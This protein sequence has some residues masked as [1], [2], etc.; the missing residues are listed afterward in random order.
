MI[1]IIVPAYNEEQRIEKTLLDYSDYF[2]KNQKD[3]EIIVVCDG[4]DRTAKIVK[5]IMNDRKNIRMAEFRKKLGKGGA[6]IEGF[7]AAKG[8]IIGFTD[9]DESVSPEDFYMLSKRI[10]GNDCV[11][12]S[13][14]ATGAKILVAQPLKRRLASRLFNIFI[15]VV[16]GLGVK[17]TQCGVKIARKSAI[18][19][20]ASN[21]LSMGFEFDVEFL[22]L[23][24]KN[25]FSIKE[26][27]ITWKHTIHSSFSLWR[28]PGMIYSLLR[29]RFR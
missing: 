28:G 24:K 5:S 6:I 18:D 17:D 9:A 25:G 22:W 21:I 14:R 23:L 27:P 29:V 1:S 8:D 13:R 11:I 4:I 16:F 10:N 2:S 26:M 7:K 20:V 12:G 19:S 3:Y 15:N